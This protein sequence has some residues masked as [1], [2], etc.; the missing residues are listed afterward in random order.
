MCWTELG[1]KTFLVDTLQQLSLPKLFEF[2][3]IKDA[4][5]GTHWK[6]E[7]DN[8]T[9]AQQQREHDRASKRI[10]TLYQDETNWRI[11]PG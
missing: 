3:L 4:I 5:S 2:C 10:A 9:E 1:W 7:E 6:E 8:K 11:N